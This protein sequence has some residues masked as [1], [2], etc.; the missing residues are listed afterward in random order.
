M[1]ALLLKT[2]KGPI[3]FALAVGLFWLFGLIFAVV[4]ALI[5]I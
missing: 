5:P 3:A 4:Y 1:N 2:L